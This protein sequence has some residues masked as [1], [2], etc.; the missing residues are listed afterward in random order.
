MPTIPLKISFCTTCMN[1]VEHLQKTLPQNV[2]N[3]SDYSNIEF[4]ILDYNST[5]GLEQW[6]RKSLSGWHEKVVYYKTFEPQSYA[7]SH[8]RNM[9]FRLATGDI[10]CNL[11]ADNFAG[12]GF[13]SFINK[14][15][16]ANSE[17]YLSAKKEGLQDIIGKI[18]FKKNDF[19]KVGGYDEEIINYGFEDND[20]KNRLKNSGL[21]PEYFSQ[22]KFIKVIEHKDIERIKNESLFRNLNRLFVKKMSPWKSQIL[23]IFNDLTYESA[24]IVDNLYKSPNTPLKY[25]QNL[26]TAFRFTILENSLEKGVF[27]GST[28]N[29]ELIQNEEQILNIIYFYSQI[30]NKGI[31]LKNTENKTIKVNPDGYGKGLVYRNFDYSNPIQL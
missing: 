4:V 11:D 22:S 23:I 18:C 14:M 28:L 16:I 12:K 24:I 10:L 6:M 7:R 19:E 1:R 25:I 30:N 26:E 2:K 9:A 15:F 17:I 8:S 20:I 5:D 21:T 13:A 27:N 3:N 29:F 31:W